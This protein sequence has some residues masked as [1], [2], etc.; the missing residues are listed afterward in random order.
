MLAEAV[1][2][3]PRYVGQKAPLEVVAFGV[4]KVSLAR[5]KVLGTVRAWCVA[6]ES[7]GLWVWELKSARRLHHP[8]QRSDQT[9]D[10]EVWLCRLT[11]HVV[12]LKFSSN[13]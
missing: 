9:W 2:I 7:L 13:D 4:S 12:L 8:G 5:R 6:A 1:F 10:F 11:Y 3:L